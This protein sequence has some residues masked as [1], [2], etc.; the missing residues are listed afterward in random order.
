[1]PDQSAFN[2]LVLKIHIQENQECIDFVTGTD[3]AL[4]MKM[5]GLSRAVSLGLNR[6]PS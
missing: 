2:V 6:T 1:M 4:L 5:N 3:S